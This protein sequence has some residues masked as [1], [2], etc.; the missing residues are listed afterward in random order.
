MGVNA[1]N[2]PHV[3]VDDAES[4]VVIRA[5]NL[6]GGGGCDES[7]EA[8]VEMPIL[9][10]FATGVRSCPGGPWIDHEGFLDNELKSLGDYLDRQYPIIY[11]QLSQD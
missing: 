9:D 5:S 1:V 3:I 11:A 6:Y 7:F 4:G 2:Y 10:G 8:T